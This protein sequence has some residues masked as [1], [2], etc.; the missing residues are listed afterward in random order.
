MEA[1]PIKRT[2]KR[3]VSAPKPSPSLN[4][5]R[6]IAVTFV[7][8]TFATL[9]VVVYLSFSRATILITPAAHAVSTTFVADVVGVPADET[10]VEGIVV[11][12]TFEQASQSVL[13]G[14]SVIPVDAKA[15]GEVT[16]YNTTNNDQP[17]VVN[18]R[19]L[20]P[21][22]ILFRLDEGVTVPAQ[23]SVAVAVHADVAGASGDIGPTRF[24]IPGLN[25]TL[26]KVIYAESTEAFTG[27][28]VG[29][30]IVEQED[31]DWAATQL[32]NEMLEAAK[33]TLRLQAGADYSGEAFVT[34]VLE[35]RSDT[36]PGVEATSIGIAL[37]MKV[38]AVFYDADALFALAQAKLYEQMA[39]GM[40]VQE[41]SVDDMQVT[42]DD[43]D[44]VSQIINLSITL[45]GNATLSPTNTL[46]DKQ[47]FVGR[48]AAEVKTALESSDAIKTVEIRFTPFWLKRLP[49]LKDHIKI[50]IE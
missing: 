49:T 18:T 32:E 22:N 11:S 44:E 42:I 43:Y 5:Y 27:G 39:Q 35:K 45:A 23:G 28:V 30:R 2:T 21:E 34:E 20:S 4:L 10:D 8:A 19:L 1:Q 50:V 37:K 14:D 9:A 25:E 3:K 31:L 16:I 6:R 26:Q 13:S 29:L 24:T 33:E 47:Q 15:V 46:L 36:Q 41:V 38:V 7:I 40:A 48:G 17:L 12:N